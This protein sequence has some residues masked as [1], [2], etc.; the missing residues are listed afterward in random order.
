MA[1]PTFIGLDV[2]AITLK[3]RLFGQRTNNT[4]HYQLLA[5]T[6]ATSAATIFSAFNVAFEDLWCALVSQD[7][8][9]D[10]ITLRRLAPNPTRTMEF[11]I[12]WTGA[13][14]QD[15][16]PPSTAAVISRYNYS[17]G[18]SGRGRLFIPG[19]PAT[20]HA[21]GQLTAPALAIAVLLAAQVDDF[22]EDGGTA[23][24]EPGLWA[25]ATSLFRVTEEAVARS[26][27][28]QQRRREIGVGE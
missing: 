2:V 16:L 25:R 4:F 15:S 21:E 7:W 11:N 24:M 13:V 1:Q 23:F 12:A 27:L 9:A 20:F 18:P 28:R 19:I 17:P 8:T 5:G 26:I 10:L 3:G 14:A 22:L 6:P